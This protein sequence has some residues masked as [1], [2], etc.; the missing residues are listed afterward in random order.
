VVAFG[1]VA[2][3][4]GIVGG[5]ALWVQEALDSMLDESLLA[6][7][8]SNLSARFS[9]QVSASRMLLPTIIM[10]KDQESRDRQLEQLSEART[11]YQK[12]L[13]LLEAS[14]QGNGVGALVTGITEQS[15]DLRDLNN[16]ILGLA[17]AGKQDEA[18]GLFMGES[19]PRMS[20]RQQ[21]L[22]Q[23]A[24]QRDERAKDIHTKA[25]KVQRVGRAVVIGFVVGGMLLS[26]L[27]A[28]VITR[29]I[30]RP[31]F[32]VS[33]I[34]GRVAKGDLSWGGEGA[35]A[36]RKDE[37]GDLAR[38][39][40]EVCGNLRATISEVTT[41]VSLMAN[42]S[43]RLSTIAHEIGGGARDM[44]GKASS[45]AAAAEESSSTTRDV[46]QAMNH[47]STSLTSVAGA[48]EQM[49]STI[50][51]ISANAE[52]S[53]AISQDATQQA[54]TI[55]GVM[56]DLGQA[57]QDIGKVTETITTISAQTNLLALNATIEAARAGAA[58]KGFAVVANEIKELAQQTASATED[59]KQKIGSIQSSTGVAINDIQRIA[60]V[61]REVGDIVSQIATSIE[62]QSKATKS[63][64]SNVG[65]ASV[66][67][68]DANA[69]I[70]QTAEVA[71]G[72]ARD[73]AS[74]NGIAGA[75]ENDS[76]RVEESA[77]E[78]ATLSSELQS[79]MNQF[80]VA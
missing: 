58:G 23:I 48:T 24:A 77:R 65:E 73:I 10:A 39:V 21:S 61:I 74:V 43:D 27:L 76:T 57:A 50:G 8:E 59:I 45:V 70:A 55:S 32:E 56:R 4:L 30:R 63:V 44:A 80:K 78:L 19:L 20:K 52:R 33:D 60:N 5:V 71:H 31:I 28:A 16:K 11:E 9:T 54:E 51:E 7:D 79:R 13:K 75:R 49:S 26:L 15:A 17:K 66:S 62:E 29:G 46:A 38:A 68:R 22:D 1:G 40:G 37:A 35:I 67:V 42:T 6:L 53:R 25:T 72:I 69:R 2:L 14:L 12:T 47:T 34:L 36:E 41:G 64:A 18:I 3:I